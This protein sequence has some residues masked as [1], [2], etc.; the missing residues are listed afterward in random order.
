VQVLRYWPF[1]GL[2]CRVWLAVDVWMCTAS[3]LNLCAISLD[4]YVAI[5]RPVKYPT[6]MSPRRARLLIVAVWIVSFIILLP[7]PLLTGDIFRELV[8][9]T[10]T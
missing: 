7:V 6:V 3:I 2:W 9:L 8:T 1:G 5:S 10:K 4:R